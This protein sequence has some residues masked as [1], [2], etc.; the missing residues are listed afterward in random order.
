MVGI[1]NF[2]YI[3]L[4]DSSIGFDTPRQLTKI[5]GEPII[6]RT[7]RLLKEN[8]IKN[9]IITS[10][11]TR[12]DNLGVKRYAPRYNDY[13]PEQKKGYWVS[14]F[15]I[16]LLDKPIVFLMGDVYY[17]ENAIKTIIS[18]P[19]KSILYFCSYK[20]KSE[21]YIKHHDEPL[22]F[23]VVDYIMF[24]EHIERVKD[25]KDSGK[26][27]RE[28]IA[29]EL[30]RSINNQPLTE[31]YMTTNY[32]AINDE[33]CDIDTKMDIVLLEIILGGNMFKLQAT[34]DFSLGR[35]NEIKEIERHSNKNENGMVYSNDII[36][37]EKDLA[38]YLCGENP[39]HRTVVNLLELEPSKED[40]LIT[41]ENKI[42]QLE[43]EANKKST[44]KRQKK[45]KN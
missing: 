23:K 22:G 43:Q 17:S 26:A 21:K 8:G 19:T 45:S 35:F 34:E 18:S 11:D 1:D 31:H 30:Y 32:I 4:A 5:K 16:E 44:K 20:N 13:N 39:L 24:K 27:I 3:I 12:F 38:M 25:Y 15:P 9:I 41:D 37:C 2:E 29:W 33:S 6:A 40:L 36:K 28:P 7:I 42:E 14:A 10:H